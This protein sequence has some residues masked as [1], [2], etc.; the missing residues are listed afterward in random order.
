MRWNL[1]GQDLK[2]ISVHWPYQFVRSNISVLNFSKLETDTELFITSKRYFLSCLITGGQVLY[3]QTSDGN[4]TVNVRI[5]YGM[6]L[7]LLLDT[8]VQVSA[9]EDLAFIEFLSGE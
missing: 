3:L 6:S 8:E 5:K 7:K 9:S 2:K 1:Q 4:R